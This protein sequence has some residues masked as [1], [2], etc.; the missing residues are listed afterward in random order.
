M[1]PMAAL[2]WLLAHAQDVA[3]LETPLT[4]DQLRRIAARQARRTGQPPQ[5]VRHWAAPLVARHA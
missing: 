1:S 5:E 3:M 4:P 2:E